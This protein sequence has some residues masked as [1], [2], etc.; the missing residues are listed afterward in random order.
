MSVSFSNILLLIIIIINQKKEVLILENS[1][2]TRQRELILDCLKKNSSSHLTIQE[3]ENFL[4]QN[5][6]YVGTATI[7]RHL[8]KL[9]KLNIVRKFKLSGQNG[10]CY[11]FIS[12]PHFCCEHFH[13]ICSRCS[14]TIHFQN[15]K[16]I[17]LFFEINKN[18]SFKI[19]FPKTIFYGICE[20]CLDN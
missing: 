14:K 17:Q 7:Y 20:N 18:N 2:N 4:N 13:L 3:I 5:N 15:K 6:N 1:R 19:D 10:A 11:Q 9:L 16:L 8:N 12:N